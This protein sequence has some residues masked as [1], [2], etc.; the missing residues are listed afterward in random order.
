M[1]RPYNTAIKGGGNLKIRDGLSETDHAHS[2]RGTVFAHN[3][4][5]PFAP[6]QEKLIRERAACIVSDLVWKAGWPVFHQRAGTVPY[7]NH[8]DYL[9]LVRALLNHFAKPSFI[10][11][12]RAAAELIGE[13]QRPI[14]RFGGNVWLA[15]AHTDDDPE[16]ASM[17]ALPAALAARYPSAYD[18]GCGYGNLLRP[19]GYFVG[20]DIDRKCL[21]Y[22]AQEM[23]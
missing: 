6:R 15:V 7:G 9:Y 4:F 21:A 11:C 22:I 17:E 2:G 20:S 19:F 23:L 3:V 16:A 14:K 10:V 5:E 8:S 13:R 12:S 18:F 1:R